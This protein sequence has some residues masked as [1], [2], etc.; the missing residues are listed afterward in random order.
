MQWELNTE[1]PV[2]LQLVE[3]IQAKIISG[4]YKPGDK[5]PSVRDLAAQAMVNPNTMQRAMTELERDGLVYT[6]RT[7]GRF[8]TS[9]E[10]LI[11][12]LKTEYIAAIVQDFL[13]KM[14]QLGLGSDEIIS[15]LNII[16]ENKK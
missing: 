14:K 5:L 10:E 8:I 2:Y 4:I 16:I 6:N 1:K 3:Q 13:D 7:A 15:Y 9:D 11:K 12:Q